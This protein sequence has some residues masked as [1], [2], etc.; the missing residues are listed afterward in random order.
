MDK[1]V[2]DK[3]VEQTTPL[4]SEESNAE[5]TKD[6]GS[7][8]VET[9]ED[10]VSEGDSDIDYAAELQKEIA[11]GKEKDK[12][13]SQAQHTI[14]G[15]KRKNKEQSDDSYEEESD[16]T[17]QPLTV[18]DLNEALDKRDQKLIG[19]THVVAVRSLIKAQTR[20]DDEAKLALHHYENSIVKTGD[21]EADVQKA[22]LLANGARFQN[23]MAE[24]R[25]SKESKDSKGNSSGT[26]QKRQQKKE[27]KITPEEQE[28]ADATN[29]TP[30]DVQK[31]KNA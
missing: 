15:L 24:V 5:E 26:G 20:N 28:F 17:P 7:E 29:L 13:L 18:E 27:I 23:I 10:T 14:V 22:I 8:D 3:D 16:D 19:Q 1:E 4:A 6:T 11:R 31:A 12:E 25:L 2:K 21:D 9:S 30:E